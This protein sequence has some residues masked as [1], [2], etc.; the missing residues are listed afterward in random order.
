MKNIQVSKTELINKLSANLKNH[1]DF[2]VQAQEGYRKMVIAELDSMLKDA[3]ENKKI[4]T[5]IKFDAP[6]NHSED[7]GR[8]IG[9]LRMS[10]D[11]TVELSEEEFKNYV[12][13][14]WDWSDFDFAN[15]TSYI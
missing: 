4:R 10:I 13:D 3:R 8:V 12:L 9:M 7:Y 1:Y 14:K 6:K 15:K 5:V 2:F 11:E